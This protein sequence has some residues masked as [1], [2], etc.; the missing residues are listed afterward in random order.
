MKIKL[1]GLS[2][3]LASFTLVPIASADDFSPA[4]KFKIS[5]PSASCTEFDPILL[6]SLNDKGFEVYYDYSRSQEN[7]YGFPWKKVTAGHCFASQEREV[8]SYNKF[9]ALHEK[10]PYPAIYE[11]FLVK[12]E[13]VQDNLNDLDPNAKILTTDF[14]DS[15]DLAGSHIDVAVDPVEGYLG[16]NFPAYI[17]TNLVAQ[18]DT[19][20]SKEWQARCRGYNGITSTVYLL[21]SIIYPEDSIRDI[22]PISKNNENIRYV[23]SSYKMNNGSSTYSKVDYYYPAD[24]LLNSS[25]AKTCSS[26]S[27]DKITERIVGLNWNGIGYSRRIFE[28]SL[29]YIAKL[30]SGVEKDMNTLTVDDFGCVTQYD[31]TIDN[32]NS[33]LAQSPDRHL[34]INLLMDG[35]ASSTLG[36]RE[37]LISKDISFLPYESS[38]KLDEKQW[39]KDY[40]N[41]DH[42]KGINV[43]QAPDS[44]KNMLVEGQVYYGGNGPVP[45]PPPIGRPQI[46]SLDGEPV[47]TPESLWYFIVGFAVMGLVI[48]ELAVRLRKKK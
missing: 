5:Y 19:I 41:T 23:T 27:I 4:G 42:Y 37:Y 6:K 30:K 20:K 32:L 9:I 1:F 24:D 21:A 38:V 31:K 26:K 28:Y 8:E 13:T 18:C 25:L 22:D 7:Q 36:G 48:I 29:E 17:R 35:I 14:F 33:T 34:G 44:E 2:L 46:V 43:D 15:P 39:A 16:L 40:D 10:G 47:Y 12:K 3:L 45:T 11:F